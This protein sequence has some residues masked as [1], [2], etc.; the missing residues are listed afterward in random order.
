MNRQ[1][2]TGTEIFDLNQT[3]KMF[4][5]NQIANFMSGEI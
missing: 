3:A 4:D 2:D 1:Y 5:L